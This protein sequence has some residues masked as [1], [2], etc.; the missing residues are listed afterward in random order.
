MI[1]FTKE[2]LQVKSTAHANWEAIDT[3]AKAG[4]R[5]VQR[6]TA[7]RPAAVSGYPFLKNEVEQILMERIRDGASCEYL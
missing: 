6:G 5:K 4:P 1:S 3:P 2:L 7:D